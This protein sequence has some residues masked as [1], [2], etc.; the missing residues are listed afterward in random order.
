MSAANDY[1]QLEGRVAGFV[2]RL[3]ALGIDAVLLM[4]FIGLLGLVVVQIENLFER[5]LPRDLNLQN[6]FVLA[7]PLIIAF[8][9]V[10]LWALTGATVGKRILGLRVVSADGFPPTIGRSLIR[11]VG[12]GLSALVFFL[13]FLWVLVDE[14]RRAWHDELAGTWVVYDF[15]RR[16][17]GEV[18]SHRVESADQ[19][20]S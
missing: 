19:E 2:S 11:L 16:H 17:Q 13:G 1:N 3:V 7:T 4:V 10:G 20:P 5:F 8:Y 6:L 15:S 9:F 12:Y 18:Y 14:D